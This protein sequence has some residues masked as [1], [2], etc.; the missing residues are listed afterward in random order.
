MVYSMKDM[1]SG[2]PTAQMSTIEQTIPEGVEEEK[3]ITSE[4]VTNAEGQLEVID[5]NTIWGAILLTIGVLVLVHF[6]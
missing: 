5:K 2:L 3:Y 1:Y 4:T 6:I